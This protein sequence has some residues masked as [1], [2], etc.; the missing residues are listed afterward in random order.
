[1]EIYALGITRKK[2][3]WIQYYKIVIN[4]YKFT[5]SKTPSKRIL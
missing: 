2:S 4:G 1:M 3:S 5:N